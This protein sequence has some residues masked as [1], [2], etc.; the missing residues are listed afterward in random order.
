MTETACL[1]C[2]KPLGSFRAKRCSSCQAKAQIG[3]KRSEETCKNISK[4]RLGNKWGW[5]GGIKTVKNGYRMVHKPEHPYNNQNYVWEHRLVAEK[6]LGRYLKPKEVV[7]HLDGDG[8][9]NE[10]DN[11]YVFSTSPEHTR[12]H[13]FLRQ[14][15]R[16]F[17][18]QRGD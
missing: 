2:D 4:S 10:E 5:K 17:L 16:E 7:H 15:V 12:Y 6:M 13:G 11:L 1:D 3:V 9:N 14:C 8:S 18:A